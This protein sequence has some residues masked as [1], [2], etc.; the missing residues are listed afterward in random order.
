MG[1]ATKSNLELPRTLKPKTIVTTDELLDLT[2]QKPQGFGNF[3]KEGILNPAIPV[4][5]EAAQY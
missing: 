5:S 3:I 4:G 1:K 2:R